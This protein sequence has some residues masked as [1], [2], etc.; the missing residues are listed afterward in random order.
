MK[1]MHRAGVLALFVIALAGCATQAEALR[2]SPDDENVDLAYVSQVEDAARAH[3]VD[4]HWVNPPHKH[5][6]DSK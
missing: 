5:T 2:A 4:V 3:F 6:P 1:A